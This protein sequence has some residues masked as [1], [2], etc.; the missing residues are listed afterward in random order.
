MT[1]SERDKV[2]FERREAALKL[3]PTATPYDV[4]QWV[5]R[6]GGHRAH[7][8]MCQCGGVNEWTGL[9]CLELWEAVIQASY[10]TPAV[11][12]AM[13]DRAQ[14]ER[15]EPTESQV[16]PPAPKGAQG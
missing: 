4:L 3:L 16:Q 10:A 1:L 14:R 11:E 13:T 12:A 8:V 15:I 9:S 5:I 6:A 7:P 2:L